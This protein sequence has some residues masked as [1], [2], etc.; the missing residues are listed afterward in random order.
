MY[1]NMVYAVELDE[2]GKSNP[3]ELKPVKSPADE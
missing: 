2:N 1:P 3:V